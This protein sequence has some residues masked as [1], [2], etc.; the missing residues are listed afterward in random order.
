MEEAIPV[1]NV[2]WVTGDNTPDG[3]V[4]YGHRYTISWQRGSLTENGRNGAFLNEVL[5]ECYKYCY[6]FLGE[7]YQ[8]LFAHG[9]G[10]TIL[11]DDSVLED[12][13]LD[14]V[15]QACYHQFKFMRKNYPQFD[16]AENS[17][18]EMCLSKIQSLFSDGYNGLDDET[19]F[20]LICELL[21]TVCS[22]TRIRAE[23]R[24]AN[25]TLGTHIAD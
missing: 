11:W 19:R 22:S 21:K 14:R 9:Q 2:N 16:C 6:S 17:V 15:L 18:C 8:V 24:K 7:P 20:K 1:V 3:G 12:S 5:E 25:G 23:R 13:V 4:S 10:Y